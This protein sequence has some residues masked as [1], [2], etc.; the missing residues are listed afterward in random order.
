MIDVAPLI[1]ARFSLGEG[2]QALEQTAQRGVLK[3]LL[4]MT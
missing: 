1:H 4:T 3:V 2:I